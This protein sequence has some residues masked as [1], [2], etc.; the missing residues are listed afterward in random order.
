M[1]K[2]IRYSAEIYNSI[3]IYWESEMNH[4][5]LGTG[6]VVSYIGTL[7]LIQL[8]MWG[9]VP[10]F[11]N[12][13]IP[14]NHFAAVEVAFIV[15]LFFEVMSLIFILP[16]SVANSL[17]KQFEIISLIL[18]RNAFKEFSHFVEPLVLHQNIETILHILSDT[19]SALVVFSGLYLVRSIRIHKLIFFKEE[20]QFQFIRLKKM[21]SLLL[22]FAFILLAIQDT[23]LYFTHS[24]TF[25]F[26]PAFY[27]ILIFTDILMVL[28]SLRYNYNYLVLFR[29]SGFALATVLLRLALS[30]PVYYNALIAI[31]A[32]VFVYLLTLVYQKM[33]KTEEEQLLN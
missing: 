33:L 32:I 19:F 13:F 11:A 14:D 29:N 2:I 6:I 22:M 18:L 23:I 31:V 24:D 20:E 15:L 26:F 3:E 1:K 17:Y 16:Q 9:L 10:G 12:Q 5:I 27:T 8:K 7:L 30:A 21:T 25:K 28:I 4:R